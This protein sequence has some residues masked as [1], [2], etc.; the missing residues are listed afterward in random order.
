MTL[1]EEGYISVTFV[2]K[3]KTSIDNLSAEI[4]G[5]NLA[6]PGQSQFVGNIAAGTENSVDFDVAALE[7]GTI[8][9]IITLS[10]EDSTGAAKTLTTNYSITVNEMPAMEDPGMMDPGMMEPETEGGLPVGVIVVIVIVAA[11]VI[12]L[13]VRI[14]LKKRKAKALAA[15][16]EDD[17]DL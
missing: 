5:D 12:A 15:L 17:E 14:V 1:G 16:G 4:S 13:V 8:T 6:N 7:A 3:G 10:Y 2:N 11:G 9:G